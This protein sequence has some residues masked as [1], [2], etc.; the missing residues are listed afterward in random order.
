MSDKPL[1]IQWLPAEE[2]YA[3]LC[4][5]CGYTGGTDKLSDAEADGFAHVK[6]CRG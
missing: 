6:G 4:R 3:W 2:I 1:V 5:R